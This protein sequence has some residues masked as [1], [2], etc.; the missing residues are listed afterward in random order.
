MHQEVLNEVVSPEDDF[1][2]FEESIDSTP[3]EKVLGVAYSFA[4]DE[5]S[6]WVN[7]EKVLR[8]VKT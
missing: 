7:Q 4:S 6:F 5:F 2:M 8:E 1:K 3:S